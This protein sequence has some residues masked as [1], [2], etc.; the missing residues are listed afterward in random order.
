MGPP[1]LPRLTKASV[2]VGEELGR[3]SLVCGSHRFEDLRFV[4]RHGG[5]KATQRAHA[6][7][8]AGRVSSTCRQQDE[9]LGEKSGDGWVSGWV[10]GWVEKVGVSRQQLPQQLKRVSVT[11][12]V[13]SRTSA[14]KITT[15]TTTTTLDRQPDVLA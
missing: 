13:T 6:R 2:E 15:A 11:A 5:P 4:A 9:Q 8:A 3:L 10:G 7:A 1:A 14:K 12:A